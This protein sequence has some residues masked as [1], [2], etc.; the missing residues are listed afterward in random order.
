LL[1]LT[2]RKEEINTSAEKYHSK[3]CMF[4]PVIVELARS[5]LFPSPYI[6]QSRSLFLQKTQD[7]DRL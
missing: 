1:T 7:W 6:K 5:F 3:T 2:Y 4:Q